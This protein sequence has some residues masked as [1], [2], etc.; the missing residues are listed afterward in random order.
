MS[1]CR[2]SSDDWSCDVYVYADVAG[3]YTIHV[4]GN[5]IVGDIPKAD[6]L[7][8]SDGVDWD[9]EGYFRAHREQMDFLATAEREFIDLPYSGEV[10]RESTAALAIKR[11]LE[12]RE[13][14]YRVPGYAIEGLAEEMESDDS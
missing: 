12:L 10:F 6:H 14:G 3:G 8:L 4:A 2:F 7:W 5:R 11:L 1:F 9:A 13:L